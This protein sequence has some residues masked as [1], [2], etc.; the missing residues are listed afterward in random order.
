MTNSPD[1]KIAIGDRVSITISSEHG[2]VND[3]RCT[4]DGDLEVDLIWVDVHGAAHRG[5][6]PDGALMK[7]RDNVV[8]L[9]RVQ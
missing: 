7:L 5:W 8:A 6:W 4:P 2:V 9:R 1:E 3:F